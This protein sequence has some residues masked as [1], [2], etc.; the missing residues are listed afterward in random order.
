MVKC[1]LYETKELTDLGKESGV[2]KKLRQSISFLREAALI[3]EKMDDVIRLRE[4]YYLMARVFHLLNDVRQRD[5]A[6]R[7]FCE[8]NS[9]KVSSIIPTWCDSIISI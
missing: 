7:K 6:S 2:C 1:T 8:A 3:F 9:K 4:V 5:E